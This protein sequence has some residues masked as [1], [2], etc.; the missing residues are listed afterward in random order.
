MEGEFLDAEQY[1]GEY[2]QNIS[3]KDIMLRHLQKIAQMSCQ[4]FTGGYW[5]SKPMSMGSVATTMEVYVPDTREAYSNAIDCLHDLL[6]PYFDKQCNEEIKVVEEKLEKLRKESY[7]KL[8]NGTEKFDKQSYRNGKV[9]IKRY[10]LRA[11][12]CFLYR[13]KYLELKRYEE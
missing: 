13:K 9:Q 8:E 11:L 2:N 5:N 10:L 6:I 7:H 1:Q 12:T 4:E 3:F